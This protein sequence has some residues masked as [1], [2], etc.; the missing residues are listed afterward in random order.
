[1]YRIIRQKRKSLTLQWTDTSELVVKAPY[2]VTDQQIETFVQKHR[3]WIEKTY[4]QRKLQEQQKDWLANG[5][6]MYLGERKKIQVIACKN[7]KSCVQSIEDA[8]L[9][10]V[11][12][13]DDTQLIRQVMQSYWK[14]IAMDLFKQLTDTYCTLLGLT[15]HKLTIRSQKT[16]WG[17]C[18][19]KGNLS[20]NMRL[21]SAPKEVI[22]YVVLHEVMHLRY[23]NHGIL[24]WR[25]IEDYMPEYKKHQQY[26]K[27]HGAYLGI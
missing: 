12:D 1:M 18:S 24:F 17:S 5:Y 6:C 10:Y 25:T 20:Y 11:P 4:A 22:A 16:R 7:T 2:Y 27:Q 26:L 8:F 13:C 21:L 15:Y 23:F 3:A 9:V 14:Q 19:S